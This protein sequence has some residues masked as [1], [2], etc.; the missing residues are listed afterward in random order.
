VTGRSDDAKA[1]YRQIVAKYPRSDEAVLAE[2]FLG[3]RK[4]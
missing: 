3:T 2:G 4:P 1:L